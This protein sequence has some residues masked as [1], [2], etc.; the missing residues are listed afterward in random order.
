M[1]TLQMTRQWYRQTPSS[2]TFSGSIR[3]ISLICQ[4]LPRI[5]NPRETWIGIA[6][7]GPVHT[8][9]GPDRRSYKLAQQ[10][11]QRLA[12]DL[13]RDIRDGTK[14]LMDEYGMGKDD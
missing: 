1:K 3:G 8:K 7:L 10:D 4:R 13:L 6:S 2:C 9:R 14:A 11:A 5:W 12:V